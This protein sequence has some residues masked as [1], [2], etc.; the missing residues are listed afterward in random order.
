M[1]VRI[2][3]CTVGTGGVL[4]VGEEHSLPDAEARLLIALGKATPILAPLPDAAAPVP[5]HRDPKPKRTR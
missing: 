3:R 1:R 2:V 4:G 5:E